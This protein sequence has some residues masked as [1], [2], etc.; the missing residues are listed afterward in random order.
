M[1]FYIINRDTVTRRGAPG[2]RSSNLD[3]I[4][5]TPDLVNNTEYKMISDTW[6][7][8][9]HPIEVTFTSFNPIPYRKITNRIS[10]KNTDWPNYIDTMSDKWNRYADFKENTNPNGHLEIY[11]TLTE[12]MREAVIKANKK[13]S[14]GDST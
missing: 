10:T 4:L 5:V 7:S 12:D 2:Q 9:H 14:Y 6:G 11:K 13:T 1:D 8:D 3:L